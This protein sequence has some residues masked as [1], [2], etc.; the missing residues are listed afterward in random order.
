MKS[1]YMLAQ[2]SY[3]KNLY[4]KALEYLDKII[5]NSNKKWK[6]KAYLLQ[7][8]IYFALQDYTS[9]LRATAVSLAFSQELLCI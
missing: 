1:L 3:R 5:Q 4:G 9:A 8:E 2:T 7:A 6:P